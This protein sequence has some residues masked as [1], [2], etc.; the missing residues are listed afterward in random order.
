MC[1]IRVYKCT[2][3][4]ITNALNLFFKYSVNMSPHFPA[5]FFDCKEV[6][7]V[8]NCVRMS[9]TGQHTEHRNSLTILSVSKGQNQINICNIK[10]NKSP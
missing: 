4:G 9:G 10:E 5:Q 7:W 1:V 2:K 6:Q 8:P 3:F